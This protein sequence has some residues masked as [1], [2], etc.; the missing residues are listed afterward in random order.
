[1]A[2]GALL[3]GVLLED[4]LGDEAVQTRGEHVAG[5]AEVTL[6]RVKAAHAEK[7]SRRTRIVQRSPTSSSVRAIEQFCPL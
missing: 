6:D 4:A 3:V 7:T 2:R 5:D 1:M